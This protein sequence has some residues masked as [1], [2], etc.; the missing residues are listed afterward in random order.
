MKRAFALLVVFS[1]LM[2]PSLGSANPNGVGEGTFDA[3]CGGACHGDADMNKSSPATVVVNAPTVA[4]EGLL[5][6]VSIDITNIETSQTGILGVFLL[7]DLSGAGDTPADDGWTVISNSEGGSENYVEVTVAAGTT[8][9]TVTWTLRAPSEGEYPL[10]GAIHHG[11]QD[12]SEAPFFGASVAPEVVDVREVPEDLPRLASSFVPPTQRSVGES[13]TVVL[14]TEFVNDVTVEWRVV[15]GGINEAQPTADEA[16]VWSFELPASLQ[17][18]VVEWRVHL[19]GEG[20]EQ[21]SPWFQ[22][23]SDDPAWTVDET[24]AYIQSVAM[25]LAFMAAFMTLQRRGGLP[26]QDAHEKTL[27]EF[28]D[29][30]EA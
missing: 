3:Q 9:A 21:T 15:G 16:G 4:Y 6:S 13:T 12:G 23:R 17:P 8:E 28:E 19:E 27:A 26:I 30:G 25:L 29:G 1:L 20:P 10:H 5:T 11:T 2:V 24:A 18:S 7:S 22:L 14:E